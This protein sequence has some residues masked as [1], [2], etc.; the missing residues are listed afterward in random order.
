MVESASIWRSMP[1][2]WSLNHQ[3]DPSWILPGMR[4]SWKQP[5]TVTAISLSRAFIT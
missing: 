4:P 5:P 1:S 2:F 3:A